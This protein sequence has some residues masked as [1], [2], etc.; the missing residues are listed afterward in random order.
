MHGLDGLLLLMAIGLPLVLVAQRLG[1]SALVAY[2]VAGFAVGANG[3][4]LVS[5]ELLGPLAEVGATL[6]LFALGLELDLFA[7]RKQAKE[8]FIGATGQM[9]STL[10]AGAALMWLLGYDLRYAI[11][12]GACLTLSSTLMVLRALDEHNLRNKPAGR[13]ALSLLVTQD[14]ALPILICLVAL[15][16]PHTSADG[17]GGPTVIGSVIGITGAIL[18]TIAVRRVLATRLFQRVRSAQLPELEV[19][20]SV[21]VAVGAALIT[22]HLHL[23]AA[24][25]AFCAGLAL[26]GD[27]HRHTIE[28]ST[29]PLQGLF[30]I[31]FFAS[32]GAKFDPI[33]VIDNLPLVIGALV[34][35]VALKAA[36]AAGALN[37]AGLPPKQAIGAGIMVGQVGEFSFVIANTALGGSSEPAHVALY[38]LIVVVS[39]LSLAITPLLVALAL[40]FLPRSNLSAITDRSATVVVAGLGPVGNQV[41]ETLHRLGHRLFLVDRNPKLLEPWAKTSGVV[42]H[43]GKIEDMDDWMPSLGSRPRA[44]VLTYPIA[45]TSAIVSERLRSLDPS[46]T[47]VARAPFIA[48]VE[49]LHTAGAQ[50]VICDEKATAAALA[51]LLDE[52]LSAE[53]A[54]ETVERRS[55]Q[56]LEVPDGGEPSTQRL[57]RSVTARL[58]T[59]PPPARRSSTTDSDADEPDSKE[60]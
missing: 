2:L 51:P 17:H 34:V 14:M 22:E 55:S 31:V 25:G 10:V 54:I 27:E 35:S 7:V 41:V 47:I 42:T 28:T 39:C 24:L 8:I 33:F 13:M 21:T 23:G 40:R 37:L 60:S 5:E 29:R 44:V 4:G 3:L 11:A 30:A 49:A 56:I 15:A 57:S 18:A 32:I 16:L 45:D 46:L 38:D 12:I 36:L 26:G 53:E 50:Y 58:D 48:Q 9:G 52:A 59:L 43:Q 20:F 1:I 6:L 19:A